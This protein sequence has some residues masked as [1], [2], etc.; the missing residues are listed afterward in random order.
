MWQTVANVSRKSICNCYQYSH[1]SG[2]VYR[3]TVNFQETRV[4]IKII[5]FQ[6]LLRFS[7][8]SPDFSEIVGAL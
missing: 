2:W 5:D 7:M 1:V 8:N 6:G 4:T 3:I